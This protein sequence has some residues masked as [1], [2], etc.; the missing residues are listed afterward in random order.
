MPFPST[1]VLCASV[2]CPWLLRAGG[3]C[4]CYSGKGQ[5][6]LFGVFLV[7]KQMLMFLGCVCPAGCEQDPCSSILV[8]LCNSSRGPL[9][10]E[11]GVIKI[12]PH[13]CPALSGSNI[14][15]GC[16]I[17]YFLR[18]SL[19]LGSRQNHEFAFLFCLLFLEILA[20][21]HGSRCLTRS[22]RCSPLLLPKQSS[23]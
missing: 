9:Y 18:L 15:F 20:L 12:T 22:L 19:L 13:G 2:L 3:R 6:V 23:L 4:C 16:W 11:D 8:L 17:L 14:D 21:H 7:K 5:K 10:V 1:H